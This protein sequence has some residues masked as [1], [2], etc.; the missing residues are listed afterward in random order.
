MNITKTK[1]N[2]TIMYQS[3]SNQVL[4]PDAKW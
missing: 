4:V 2:M 1:A 3:H